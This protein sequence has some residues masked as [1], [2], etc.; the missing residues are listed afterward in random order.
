MHVVLHAGAHNTD[1]ERLVR[2]L[3]KNRDAF[4]KRGIS[5]PRPTAYRR[6]IRDL[7][8]TMDQGPL[9]EDA[10]D[11]LL[12]DILEG[13]DDPDR[14][15]FSN[16]NFFSVPKVAINKGVIYPGAEVRLARFCTLFQ[17]DQVELFLAIRNPATFLPAVFAQAPTPDF[18]D[19]MGGAD[20]RHLRWSELINRLRSHVPEAQIHVWCNEDTPLLWAQLVRD[21][22]GLEHNEK[23]VGGFDLLTEIMSGEGMKRFRAYLKQHPN[24]NEIQKRRVIAAFLDKFAL[25]DELEEEID[26]PGW[27]DSM[28]DTLSEIYDEDVYDISRIQGVT[29]VEP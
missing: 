10:H 15:L 14:I 28:L 8:Q 1:D 16:E 22:A 5:V 4:H 21:M 20:P 26:L 24:M 3:L 2:C 13:A 29:L 25:D 9:A 18:L 11:R 7:L 6:L 27:N 19:F 17:H 23:I 12:H